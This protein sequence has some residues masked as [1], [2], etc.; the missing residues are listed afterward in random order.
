L[1]KNGVYFESSKLYENKIPEW[2]KSYLSEKDYKIG[3]KASAMLTEFLGTDLT[4]IAG[5]LTKLTILV[6]KGTEISAKLI[7]E[8]IGISKD[9]N[10][11]ELQSALMNKDVLKA[12]RIIKYF[13][14]NPKNNPIVVTLS[15]LYNLFSKVLIYHSLKDKNPQSVARSLGVNPYFV[16]DYQQAAQMYNLKNAVGV[17]DLLRVTDMKSKGYSNPSVTHSDLLKELVYKICS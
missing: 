3:N 2:I 8:S 7:E 6:P 17:L 15:V 10:N 12:N 9:Y 5:E 11:F 13:E 16:K 1:Q 4:K 14:S